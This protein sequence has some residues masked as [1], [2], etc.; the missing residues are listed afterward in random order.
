MVRFITE[1]DVNAILD[2]ATTID[3]L[4]AGLAGARCRWSRAVLLSDIVTG[5]TPCRTSADQITLFESL[6][7]ALW[8]IAAANYVYDA[9]VKSG[10]GRDVDLPL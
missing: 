3:L 9:C 2:V 7:I 6:G 5:K 1:E 8:D 4:E 10:R